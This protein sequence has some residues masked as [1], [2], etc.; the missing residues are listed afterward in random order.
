MQCPDLDQLAAYQ[1]DALEPAQYQP[2]HQHVTGCEACLRELA[3]LESTVRLVAALPPPNLP[4]D[5]WQG[6]A[7]RLQAPRQH[8]FQWRRALAGTGVLAT[9]AV[10]ALL[11]LFNS[12]HSLP[13]A[14]GATASYAVRHEVLTAQDPLADRA[15][16]GVMLISQEE[17]R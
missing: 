2:I 16:L 10:G 3:G 5:L 14:T 4:P 17:E 15:S 12:A 13:V 9:L 6:V 1:M 11:A 8:G 7:A